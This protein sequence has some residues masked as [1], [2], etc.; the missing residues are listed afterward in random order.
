MRKPLTL[1]AAALA[2]GL[3][4]AFGARAWADPAAC[5]VPTE[6]ERLT[7]PVD[8]LDEA[9]RCLIGRVMAGHSTVGKIGPVH[10]PIARTLYQYLLDHPWTTALLVKGLGLG[11][12]TVTRQSPTQFWAADGDGTQGVFTLLHQDPAVRI[13]YITG[14][15][16]GRIFPVI[17]A[18]AVLFLS[19]RPGGAR[20]AEPGVET[21]LVSYIRLDNPVLNGLVRLL[22]PL[23]GDA[24]AQKLTDGM[25]AT[26]QLGTLIAQ[27]PARILREVQ[28]L[29]MLGMEEQNRLAHL[30]RTFAA[31]PHF[32]GP[33]VASP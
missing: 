23:I 25:N 11:N 21:H 13:Y 29:P 15:H 26:V 4:L 14:E 28:A 20:E 17:R 24:V 32:P 12:Y 6:L 33:S 27:D 1:L 16:Q 18:K 19:I 3:V 5:S 8:R 2:G 7:I 22:R 31:S 10:I 30:L 9:S